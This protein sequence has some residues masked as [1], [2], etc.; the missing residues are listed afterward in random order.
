MLLAQMVV[1]LK[2]NNDWPQASVRIR[3]LAKE[4]CTADYHQFVTRPGNRHIK[5][6]V[7]CSSSF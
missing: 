6:V 2:T 3:H 7:Y 4:G 5:E 1:G